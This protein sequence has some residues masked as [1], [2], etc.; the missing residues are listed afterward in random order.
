MYE[1]GEELSRDL[2]ESAKWYRK[3][4]ERGDR[5]ARFALAIVLL[6]G[7]S[8]PGYAEARGW[9]EQEAKS[10]DGRGQYCLGL[11]Y[12]HGLGLE[13]DISRATK[14]YRQ[15]AELGNA[16]AMLRLGQIYATGENGPVD[17]SEAF[18]WFVRAAI[19]GIQGA[20]GEAAKLRATMDKQELEKTNKKLQKSHL[21]P[22]KLEALLPGAGAQ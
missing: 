2:G 12:Q 3:A 15:A 8:L 7:Q 1:R 20:L 4:A 6:K 5:D 18:V 11:I 14:F 22:K 13:K 16:L 19:G 10:K 9:C 21:D 17:R